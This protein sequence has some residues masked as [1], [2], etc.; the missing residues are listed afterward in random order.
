[1]RE[2]L[3]KLVADKRVRIALLLVAALLLLILVKSVFFAQSSGKGASYSPTEREARLAAVLTAIEGV[4]EANVLISE[5]DGVPVSAV[6][7]FA[8]EDAI[9]TRM[10]LID[11]TASALN[12]ARGAVYVFPAQK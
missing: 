9:L 2:R 1:M 8:G 4:E 12:V 3:K 5:E 7:V 6:V 10:R 11:A